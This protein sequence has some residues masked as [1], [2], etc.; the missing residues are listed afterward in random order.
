ML[1]FGVLHSSC[2][3]LMIVTCAFSGSLKV[4]VPFSFSL[5]SFGGFD[6]KAE[7][8]INTT[9][10][11]A[12]IFRLYLALMKTP[13]VEIYGVMMSNTNNFRLQHEFKQGINE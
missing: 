5:N 2:L 9:S 1:V 10:G 11:E 7:Y 8:E 13:D 6:L 4:T 12:C 3:S